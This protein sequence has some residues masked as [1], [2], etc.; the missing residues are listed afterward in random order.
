[1]R[2]I[3]GIGHFPAGV[4]KAGLGETA[5]WVTRDGLGD[6]AWTKGLGRVSRFMR[7]PSKERPCEDRRASDSYLPG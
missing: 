5:A 4:N 6:L 7:G 2:E 3:F 1:M